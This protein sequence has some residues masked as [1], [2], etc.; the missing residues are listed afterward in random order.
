MNGRST[1]PKIQQRTFGGRG[2]PLSFPATSTGHATIAEFRKRLWMRSRVCLHRLCCC[3]PSRVGEAGGHCY[4]SMERRSRRTQQAQGDELQAHER[5]RV[6]PETEIDALLCAAEKDR[7]R[8]GPRGTA[9]IGAATNCL[10]SY[11]GARAGCRR[12]RSKQALED[13]ARQQAEAATGPR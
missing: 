3:V 12:S 13:E 9:R 2:L 11:S 7:C 10:S 8:R 5:D 1:A 4:P 6:S